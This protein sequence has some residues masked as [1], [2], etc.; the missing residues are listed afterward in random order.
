MAK[1]LIAL[2]ALQV[3]T[4][5]SADECD[6]QKGGLTF[7]TKCGICHVAAAGAAHTVGPNLHGI[8]GR[9]IGQAVGFTYSTA[10]AEAGGQWDEARLDS[11]LTAPQ[12]ALPG[13]AM[14]FQGLKSEAER[15]RLICFLNTLK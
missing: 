9:G 15:R 5:V 11:F 7:A 12:K 8:A 2:L 14:P 1:F 6:L 3:H 10:L 13:T 4:A